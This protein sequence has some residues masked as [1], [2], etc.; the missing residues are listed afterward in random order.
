MLSIAILFFNVNGITTWYADYM[1]TGLEVEKAKVDIAFSIITVT[2]PV[3][4]CIAG[5]VL[6]VYLGGY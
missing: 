6:S 3:F 4:G 5:G 1:K 2:G